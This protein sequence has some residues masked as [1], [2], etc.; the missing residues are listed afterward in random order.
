LPRKSNP[1]NS[2]IQVFYEFSTTHPESNTH[3]RFSQ[4]SSTKLDITPKHSGQL[5]HNVLSVKKEQPFKKPNQGF[6][7]NTNFA[8]SS[9]KHFENLK[10]ILLSQRPSILTDKKTQHSGPS[11]T[12][13]LIEKRK[14]NDLKLKPD[15]TPTLSKTDFQVHG[16][17]SRRANSIKAKNK[18]F[19]Y[20]KN[21]DLVKVKDDLKNI[22][23]KKKSKKL[24]RR[25][26]KIVA[27]KKK[28]EHDISSLQKGDDISIY[29]LVENDH[30]LN[31]SKHPNGSSKN[32]S[33]NDLKLPSALEKKF[34][35]DKHKMINFE[36]EESLKALEAY[37]LFTKS[38]FD[39]PKDDTENQ[40]IAQNN[41]VKPQ[42]DNN[43]VVD[44]R[45]LLDKN[46]FHKDKSEDYNNN[47]VGSTFNK[48]SSAVDTE[49]KLVFNNG[50]QLKS[51]GSSQNNAFQNQLILKFTFQRRRS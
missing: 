38:N 32:V 27:V 24:F 37:N 39:S 41:D 13:T 44:R 6:D 21:S 43:K 1:D 20:R 23:T 33:S 15:K 31:T 12:P 10:R 16:D 35:V 11:I 47:P 36:E 26:K 8:E 2:N 51:N 50:N 19:K 14:I 4:N 18:T 49:H 42:Y 40:K 22:K 25:K 17:K 45:F 29:S 5:R 7:M 3:A 34:I 46:S 28:D 48:K 30:D 9:K